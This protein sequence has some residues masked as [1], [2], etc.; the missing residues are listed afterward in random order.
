MLI[1]YFP[2]PEPSNRS[3]PWNGTKRA[4]VDGDKLT[5]EGRN[6]EDL[7]SKIEKKAQ[8]Y[9]PLHG[10]KTKDPEQDR[11]ELSRRFKDDPALLS[12]EPRR[13]ETERV[14]ETREYTDI[15]DAFHE[16]ERPAALFGGSR[17]R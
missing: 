4:A 12:F 9:A 14:A 15:L 8:V 1:Y 2:P 16:L 7:R 3:K 17:G 10:T 13:Q 5:P 6:L 11:R